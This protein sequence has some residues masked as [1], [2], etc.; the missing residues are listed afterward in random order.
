MLSRSDLIY[1]IIVSLKE[2]KHV[3]MNM[4]LLV[5]YCREQYCFFINRGRVLRLNINEVGSIVKL[6]HS[7]VK[8]YVDLIP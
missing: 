6:C 7:L 8:L 2:R 5:S 1:D 4:F 3:I